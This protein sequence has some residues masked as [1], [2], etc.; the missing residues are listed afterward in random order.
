MHKSNADVGDQSKVQHVA[1]GLLLFT[2]GAPHYG[3]TSYF[4][5]PQWLTTA[6]PFSTVHS[7]LHNINIP[8]M[9][10][11]RALGTSTTTGSLHHP[12]AA[13]SWTPTMCRTT[14]LSCN[15]A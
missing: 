8:G 4:L 6:S 14:A 3:S 1:C 12:P 9:R 5:L 10:I 15:E 13:T 2:C 11:S 7:L